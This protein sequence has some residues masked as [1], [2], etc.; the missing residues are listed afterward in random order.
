MKKNSLRKKLDAMGLTIQR[1]SFFL[2]HTDIDVQGFVAGDSKKIIIAFRGSESLGDW[3]TNADF[4][5]ERWAEES[6][7]GKV[8][9]GFYDALSAIWEG[10][11][12]EIRHLRTNEQSIWLTGHSLGG[13]LAIIAAATLHVQKAKNG[14]ETNG[15]Y[16]FGQPRVGDADFADFYDSRLGNKTYRVVNNNDIVTRI[17][18][19]SM[20]YSH[21]DRL[22]YFSEEGKLYSDDE[23]SWWARFWDRVRGRLDDLLEPGLDGIKD[24]SR[25]VYQELSEKAYRNKLVGRIG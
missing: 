8:H 21:A 22:L 14:F 6:G 1:E 20:G 17:P 3:K 11:V 24:H 19:Q 23:L 10:L 25:H 4:F 5:K 13:A 15:V 16:T 2:E 12:G 7:S 9:G 18:Q